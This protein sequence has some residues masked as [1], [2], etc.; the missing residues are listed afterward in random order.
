MT[1]AGHAS[2]VPLL[3]RFPFRPSLE[4]GV[5]KKHPRW[6]VSFL[7]L[8]VACVVLFALRYQETVRTT[9]DHLPQSAGTEER[10]HAADVVS[11][12][13][14]LRS[15]FLPV[16]LFTG[17]AL[18]ALV[19]FLS[20]K[21]F[22]PPEGIRFTQFLALEIH[23]ELI[24]LLS[25]VAAILRLPQ[26]GEAWL[27]SQSTDFILRTLLTTI[28]LFTLW[29]IVALTAGVSVLCGFSKRKAF[30]IVA[31]VWVISLCL[32]LGVLNQLSQVFH[33]AL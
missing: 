4:S 32:N 29:Y 25:S 31:G 19:L 22:R 6:F 16:R 27:S 23:A 8:S 30:L 11:G 3:V 18:F 7:I 21:A 14:L 9:I 17:W 28:N 5:L 20:C 24:L 33:F 10:R 15:L 1:N 12:E 26:S 13:R 2:P